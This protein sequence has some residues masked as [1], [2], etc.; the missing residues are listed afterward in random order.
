MSS[1]QAQG[2]YEDLTFLVRRYDGVSVRATGLYVYGRLFAQLEGDELLVSLPVARRHDL[3]GRGG[4]KPAQGHGDGWL[5]V[6]DTELWPEL[7]REAHEFV[8]EPPVG[9]ES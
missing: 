3:V 1:D 7:A 4:S 9:G 2:A 5:T 8:G 6:A